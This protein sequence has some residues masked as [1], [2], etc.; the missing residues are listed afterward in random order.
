MKK[1]YIAIIIVVVMIILAIAGFLICRN[2]KSENDDWLYNSGDDKTDENICNDVLES[3][4][5][6]KYIEF[7]LER[8]IMF[9]DENDNFYPNE[10]ISLIEFLDILA[11]ISF[12]RMDLEN[13]SGDDL[14]KLF[15]E[16]GVI[17]E[18]EI[19]KEEY[20]SKV[21]NYQAIIL[22]AKC[23]MKIRNY[24]Q[25]I[26]GI[27]YKDLNGISEVGQTLIAHSVARGFVP[28]SDSDYFSP[29]KLLKRAEVAEI[30]Y[31]YMSK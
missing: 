15:E 31:L 18:G 10:N 2:L 6:S 30:V 25:V 28:L 3:D 13:I 9:T 19:T 29:D 4:A 26:C 27:N 8:N 12:P 21:T 17:K 1:I 5:A 7:V 22:L 23:D 14:V 11:K 20:D 24:E 16:N